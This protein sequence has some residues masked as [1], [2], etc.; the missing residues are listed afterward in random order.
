MDAVAQTALINP[1]DTWVLWTILV[2]WAAWSIYAD[3]RYAIASKISGPVIALLGGMVLA[4]LNVIP[5]QSPVYDA[6]W[7]YI[8]PLCIPRPRHR[9]GE[10][11]YAL[12]LQLSCPMM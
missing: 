4:N 10:A 3:Q 9:P 1:N 2:G 12:A 6:V 7:E 11:Q 5:I 8:V